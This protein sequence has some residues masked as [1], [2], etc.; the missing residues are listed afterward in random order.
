VNDLQDADSKKYTIIETDRLLGDK[1]DTLT[2]GTGIEI[3]N[4]VISSLV[5][6]GKSVLLQS[7]GTHIQWKY[8]D[9]SSR[10]HDLVQ[11]SDLQGPQGPQGPQGIQG[12]QGGLPDMTGYSTTQ[13][14]MSMVQIAIGAE[15]VNYATAAQ[16]AK[17]D[18]ALQPSAPADG[19]D[20]VLVLNNGTGTWFKVAY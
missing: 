3:A 17:A 5:V 13:Q 10:W 14:I 12:P 20:Y 6:D 11:L 7:N 18:S 2:A 1:Q 19:S 4:G 9:A 16:G 15:S 8:D